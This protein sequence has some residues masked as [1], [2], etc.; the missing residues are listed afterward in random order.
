VENEAGDKVVS[1]PFSFVTIKDTAPPVISN[2]TNES[3]LYPTEDAKVQTIVNWN[4]DELSICQF[5]YRQ[6]LAD[7]GEAFPL[8]PEIEPDTAHVQ[9]V[10]EFLPATVYKFWVECKDKTENSSRSEDFVLFTPD[11]EKSILDIIIENFQGTFGWVKK[12]DNRE[13]RIDARLFLPREDPPTG[14]IDF[15]DFIDF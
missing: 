3:T 15:K 11:K 1:D 2:I 4:T 12:I 7:S 8:E 6:S 14:G 9:V 13:L 10:L 5:F